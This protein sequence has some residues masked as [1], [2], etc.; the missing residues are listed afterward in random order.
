MSG[1]FNKFTTDV[2]DAL[3]KASTYTPFS[4]VPPP[5]KARIYNTCITG[6]LSA[7]SSHTTNYIDLD[8]S[9][10]AYSMPVTGVLAGTHVSVVLQDPDDPNK[11]LPMGP[12]LPNMPN[13]NLLISVSPLNKEGFS[14]SDSTFGIFD[15]F[16]ILLLIFLIFL[17]YRQ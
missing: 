12:C 9:K 4:T 2:T 5:N 6:A 1:L 14:Y 3:K 16:L 13:K 8:I 10:D 17:I 15:L 7:N 11:V